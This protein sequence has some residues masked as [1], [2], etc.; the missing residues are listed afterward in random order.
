MS[1]RLSQA[2][3]HTQELLQDLE[4]D[5][6]LDVIRVYLT[7][8]NLFPRQRDPKAAPIRSE[9]LRDLAKH[10]KLH[11]QRNFWKNHTTKEDLVRTL[12]KHINT[13]VL[14]NEKTPLQPEPPMSPTPPLMA[15]VAPAPTRPYSAGATESPVKR[16]ISRFNTV[17]DAHKGVRVDQA[18]DPYGGDLFGQRGDY[19]SGMIYVSRLAKP[20][21]PSAVE[22][23][24][25][26][27]LDQNKPATFAPEMETLDED[28]V[29]R[30]RRLMAECA[31]SLYQL[32]LE[33][34]HE[35]SI[36][37]E[38]CVPAIVQLCN[39]DDLDVKKF[40]SATIVN[41]SV[42]PNLCPRMIEEGVL[43]GL[44]ELAK[45]QQE[46]IR[47]N[48]AIG[49]CRISY[50]RQGQHRLIQEGSVPALISMLNN[51]D[52]ET[53]EACVKTLVNIASFS[54]GNVSE[55]VISTVIRIAAK[56]DAAYDRFIVETICNLSLLTGSR[57]K[58]PDDGIL[59]PIPSITQSCHDSRV[60]T[61]IAMALSN[62]SGIDTNHHLL[63]TPSLLLALD[64]LLSRDDDTI[65]E[66]ATTAIANLSTTRDAIAMLAESPLPLRLITTGYNPGRAIQENVSLAIANMALSDEAH[67]LLLMR[68]G[69]VPLL[70]QLFTESSIQTRYNAMVALCTLMQHE[71]SRAEII[72]RDVIHY[73]IALGTTGDHKLR[74]L[75]AI[76]L[77]NFSCYEDFAPY[78]LLPDVL[79]PMIM[80]FTSSNL[81]VAPKE[82][83]DPTIALSFIQEQCLHFFYNLSFN[84]SSRPVLVQATCVAAC[85]AVF[86]KVA[87]TP[88]LNTR[89]AA[90]LAN[91]S[92]CTDAHAQML[93]DDV[94][95]LLRR[96][97]ASSAAT[98][99]LQLASAAALCNLAVPG[100]V[101]SGQAILNLL[102]DL[103]H[104]P[105]ADIALVCSLAYSKLAA[106]ASLREAL[107]KCVELPPTLVVMMRSGIEEIQIHCA[108]ALCGMACERG[109]K[110]NKHMWKEGTVSDF[111]VNSLLRINSDS[112]KVVCAKVLFNVLT[113]DDCRLAMIKDG[114]LY[115][116]IKLARLESLEIR[117]LCVT[118]LYNL[119]CDATMVPSLMEANPAKLSA[120]L[121][122]MALAPGMEV[123]L[124]EGGVLNAILA[125]CE[126]S[127]SDCM[128]YGASVLCSVS[129]SPANCDGLA[130]SA[131]LDVLK[132]MVRS[133]DPPMV[134]F[135]TN[136]LCNVACVSHLHD[137]I[138]EAE[139]I[140]A[141][142]HVV[143]DAN[144]DEGIILTCAKFLCNLTQQ[145]K[146][147]HA[148]MKHHF[149][150]TFLRVFGNRPLYTSVADVVARIVCTLSEAPSLLDAM[151]GE[152]AVQLLRMATIDA[153]PSTIEYCVVSLLRLSRGGHSGTRI[154]DDGLFDVLCAAIPIGAKTPAA[155]TTERCS[156]ILRTLSTYAMCIPQMLQDKRLHLLIHA[157]ASPGD[158]E[159]TQNCVM[160]LHN[161]TAA[162]DHSFQKTV[163]VSGVIPLLIRLARLSAHEEVRI[164]AV[165]LA[166]INCELSEADRNEIEAYE[167]GLVT[168]MISMLDMDPPAMQRAE[169]VATTMPPLLQWAPKETEWVFLSGENNKVSLL[170][171]TIP[172]A[173]TLRDDPVDAATLVPHEP[174][175]YL[176]CLPP[177]HC[178]FTSVLKDALFGSFQI[179]QVSR[180]KSRLKAPTRLAHMTLGSVLRA[181]D[182]AA[183]TPATEIKPKMPKEESPRKPTIATTKK[184]SHRSTKAT[185]SSSRNLGS[186]G[187]SSKNAV[188]E[189]LP[190]IL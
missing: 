112:T 169:K 11:R 179:L 8:L 82:E 43:G 20:E 59:D 57:M 39:Y 119:S 120:C 48:A 176:S 152:G 159:T 69:L 47:R 175:R 145:P 113:H 108:A 97:S 5:K 132:R 146:H 123:K 25:Q 128:R 91:L 95:K 80:L 103:S 100:L 166:H 182:G 136:A 187:L 32:T 134:L 28:A 109:A 88:E 33:P 71:S 41:V 111:I 40:C 83:K 46:D 30:E 162:R 12:Y 157:L 54:G 22:A 53:K 158:K 105:H 133:K 19:N 130:S 140:G 177:Q 4:R 1:H 7:R 110:T 84:P 15:P 153:S 98:K 129:M 184:P 155:E 81:P 114:V 106:D 143:G 165:A 126:H 70:M 124:M 90:M 151:V 102:I 93:Q 170:P 79:D 141:M 75:C 127:D 60:Q 137:K 104:T 44:M 62:F 77:F 185:K 61:M 55:S 135:A 52:F 92:F 168:T 36:V 10:W 73:V 63:A 180:Q 174:S 149:I 101:H 23:E 45:V 26:N 121:T 86:R 163:R 164:C 13:K 35:N 85:V 107:T 186:M 24:L 190:P 3:R 29:R 78:A 65:I 138:E 131:A 89:V 49:I 161:L 72:A 56:K 2:A 181:V 122:N 154:L 38:G 37:L 16:R 87:K 6:E 125:L 31:C 178:E 51:T 148:L 9:E 147:R 118:A 27:L 14:P 183:L 74:E 189:C 58:A 76:G 160:L 99:D 18:L 115:A 156:M 21:K 171:Q 66:M 96:L 173:W 68:H 144:E 34:G 67:R 167:P 117:I 17:P 172:V 150:R 142:L 64:T 42:D 188:A 139:L 50:E 94:L 116:L